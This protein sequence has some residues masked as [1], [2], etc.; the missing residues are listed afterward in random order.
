MIRVKRTPGRHDFNNLLT[1][2]IGNLQLI[3]I[4][5][6][7]A[8]DPFPLFYSIPLLPAPDRDEITGGVSVV[9]PYCLH[10]WL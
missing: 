8:L 6:A 2:I 10:S 3:D 1:A 5:R 7:E 9:A 4:F